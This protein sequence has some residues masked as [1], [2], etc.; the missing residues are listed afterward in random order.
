MSRCYLHFILSFILF[1]HDCC[2][3]LLL[4]SAKVQ[5]KIELC[6]AKIAKSENFAL[7]VGAQRCLTL[8]RLFFEKF[9][10]FK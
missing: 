3:R 2:D 6:K 9:G 1:H 7:A 4:L 8:L 10:R 5:L